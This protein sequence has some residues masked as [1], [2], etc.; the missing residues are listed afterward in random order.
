M[1]GES[2]QEVSMQPDSSSESSSDDESAPTV[3]AITRYYYDNDIA[4]SLAEN[5]YHLSVESDQDDD[6]DD[7]NLSGSCHT[8]PQPFELNDDSDDDTEDSDTED[9]IIIQDVGDNHNLFQVVDS[10]LWYAQIRQFLTEREREDLW[11]KTPWVLKWF[12]DDSE[13][14]GPSDHPLFKEQ[15]SIGLF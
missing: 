11:R 10:P 1:S 14:N 3:D 8:P 5:M 12:W 7:S 4:E 9:N 6:D 13:D 15:D 2:K